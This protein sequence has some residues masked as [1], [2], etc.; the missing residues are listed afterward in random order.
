MRRVPRRIIGKRIPL[1]VGDSRR[2]VAE[3]L[4]KRF[5]LGLNRLVRRRFRVRNAIDA[6]NIA[7]REVVAPL[8]RRKL[9][10]V[11]EHDCD[12]RWKVI[13][14]RSVQLRLAGWRAGCGK[15]VGALEW[16]RKGSE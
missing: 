11:F 6:K 10:R 4:S 7:A 16:Q 3:K 15:D 14:K 2:P 9:P 8:P 5:Y 1:V 13:R 12:R